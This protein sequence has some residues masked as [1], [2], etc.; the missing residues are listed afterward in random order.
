MRGTIGLASAVGLGSTFW[1]EIEL[2]KQPE[3]AG[4]LGLLLQ[5]DL[6][7]ERAAQADRAREADRAAHQAHQ[8][9]GD[10]GAQRSEERRVGKREG[11]RRKRYTGHKSEAK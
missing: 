4:A 10:G 9:L 2:E 11:T 5:L 8:L 6:E 7:P 3:R 1:L